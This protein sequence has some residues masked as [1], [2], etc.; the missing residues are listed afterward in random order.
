MLSSRGVRSVPARKR[1]RRGGKHNRTFGHGHSGAGQSRDQRN[2]PSG[3][4]SAGS[5]TT[6]AARR[7]DRPAS[8]DRQSASRIERHDD[9]VVALDGTGDGN[10]EPALSRSGET[11]VGIETSPASSMAIGNWMSNGGGRDGSELKF[12][13]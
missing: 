9:S 13:D 7:G 10:S 2:R 1:T 12:P 4:G 6:A 3:A 8:G 11:P 5:G